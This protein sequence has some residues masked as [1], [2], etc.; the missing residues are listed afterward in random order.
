VLPFLAAAA[1]AAFAAALA[2]ALSGAISPAAAA[3]VAFA[4]GVMP[5]IFG[6][7]TYFVPVLTR[8]GAVAPAM[9]RL[10]LVFLAAGL[11]AAGAFLWPVWF[12]PLVHAGAGLALLAALVMAVWIARRGRAALG[13]PHPGLR[14]YLAAVLCLALALMAALMVLALPVQRAA[15]RLFHLHLNTLGFIGLTALGTLA[16]LL[17]TTAGRP[18]PEA[19]RWLRRMLLPVLIGALLIA[20]GAA[21]WKPAAYLG[22]LLLFAPVALLGKTWLTRFRHEILH[23][24][25]AAPTLALALTGLLGLLIAGALHAGLHIG[26][27]DAIL[28][29][30]LAFLLPLIT[31]AVSQLLPLWL[32][33][34]AQTD[35]HRAAR[36]RLGRF[37]A[38]QGLVFVA[39][40]WLAALGWPHG[41]WLALAGLAAFVARALSI[42][43]LKN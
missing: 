9:R 31:G 1:L 14:W 22:A 41:I 3:H 34:G 12:N 40:G 35:W 37:A 19:A 16:V 30:A 39:V 17:P 7:M 15:L 32:K 23:P 29:F 2:L 42:C 26:G 8:S 10:P 36:A 38:L 20:A 33:P 27:G 13:A 28:G 6:A 5:L 43:L 24:H 11:L 21:T 25:G 18:D 4:A